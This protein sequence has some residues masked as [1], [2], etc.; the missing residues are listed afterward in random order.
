MFQKVRPVRTFEVVSEQIQD[1]IFSGK[2]SPGE[3]LPAERELIKEFDIS[4]RT[5]REALRVLDVDRRTHQAVATIARNP[6][7]EFVLHSIHENIHRY[8]E[9][10]LPND[11][12]VS[13]QNYDD[14]VQLVTAITEKKRDEAESIARKHIQHGWDYMERQKDTM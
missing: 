12:L 2:L 6:I 8:Y 3:K 9:N 11:R 13:Q 1:A 14:L 10:Y 4:R 5:L 7:H